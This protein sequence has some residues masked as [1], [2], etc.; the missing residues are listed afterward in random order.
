VTRNNPL[1]HVPIR[2]PKDIAVVQ[3]A[4]I[5]AAE[6]ICTRDQDFYDPLV[7][8]FLTRLGIVVTDDVSLMRRLRS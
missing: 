7:Q 5:G 3:T 6:V 2:D 4:M 8:R 1:L